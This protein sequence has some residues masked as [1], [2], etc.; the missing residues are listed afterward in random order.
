ME[1]KK[2]VVFK[3]G[4]FIVTRK[5]SFVLKLS[6]K[7]VKSLKPFCKRI[8]IAGSIRR[9]EKNPVDIDIV[10]IPKDKDKL[11]NFMKT[12]GKFIQGGEHESTWKI[13]S[14]KVEL[15]YTLVDELGATLL[16]Y[17]SR[18]GAGIGLR[19]IA[20]RKG[21]KLNN[22]GLFDKQGRKIAG[23]TEREIY[24]ALG[25]KWKIPKNR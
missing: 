2:R 7:L 1:D 25:R 4:K 8:E 12:K 19:M 15:Y 13:E 22:H 10:L 3:K 9:K 23:K 16:A 14:V 17:S 24:H 5:G 11:E 21:M 20:K 6:E 18:F